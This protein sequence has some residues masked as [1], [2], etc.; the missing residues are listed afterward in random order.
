MRSTRKGSIGLGGLTAALLLVSLIAEAGDF[1]PPPQLP[2][3]PNPADKT[4]H[5]FL[6]TF[7]IR[8]G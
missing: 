6:A 3:S 5:K 1:A 7:P 2:L 4:E 8:L